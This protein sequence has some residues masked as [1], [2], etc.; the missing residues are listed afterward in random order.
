[1]KNT[2]KIQIL[3]KI[4]VLALSIYSNIHIC[5]CLGMYTHMYAY[6]CMYTHTENVILLH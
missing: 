2:F 5:T 4:Q 6:I 1:M 3:K